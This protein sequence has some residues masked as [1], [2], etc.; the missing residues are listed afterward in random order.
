M[1]SRPRMVHD[2]MEFLTEA[3]EGI[4]RQLEEQDLL[5]LNNDDSYH[6]SGGK[7]WTRE[8]PAAGYDGRHVRPADMWAS[9]Q[10]QELAGV[11]PAMHREFAMRYEKRLLAPF[12][13]IG[14]GCCEDLTAKLD[15]VLA[16]P[17][18]WRISV[19]PFADVD[20]CAR[21]LGGRCIF[22]WKPHPAHL[23]GSF[24]EEAIRRYIGHT[25]RVCRVAGC[26]LEMILKD[27][28]TCENRPERFDRWA[29]IAQRAV[30]EEW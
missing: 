8:L 12:A 29:S 4:L 11:S 10:A 26:H 13:R 18:I 14:Y 28:H 16:I 20:A 22:S 15:D 3:H 2:A 17:R 30:A 6:S 5:D 23:V 9:A 24:D 7:G 21:K 27:T 25:L 1:L 19:S